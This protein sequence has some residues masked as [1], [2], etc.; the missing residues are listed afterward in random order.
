MK[1]QGD[2][3][4]YNEFDPDSLLKPGS[5]T[6]FYTPDS[7]NLYVKPYPISHKDMLEDDDDLFHD[8]YPNKKVNDKQR[9]TLSSRG[10]ALLYS[11]VLM[12]RIGVSGDNIIIAVWSDP[13]PELF[14]GFLVKLF[15][16]H[17]HFKN[18][19]DKVVIVTAKKQA[20]MLN[21]FM[22]TTPKKVVK[23]KVA[24]KI[25]KVLQ[26]PVQD[27]TAKYKI[28]GQNYSLA[29]L[30]RLRVSIH[31]QA[32]S[33]HNDAYSVLCHPDLEKYPELN[34]YRPA[35]CSSF[36]PIR[37]THPGNWRA[38][39]RTSGLPYIYSYGE[40]FTFKDWIEFQECFIPESN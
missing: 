23:K 19:Q 3:S 27:E 13:S 40:G 38:A 10:Q 26:A 37:K 24:S 30:Q 6:F 39:A 16:I 18:I 21:D 32:S 28:D 34:G 15:E 17:P 29:D 36:Q 4:V 8:V 2:I 33:L 20:K 12:G 14:N 31:S 11:N 22:G 7:K 9:E 25:P 1:N 35:S 5:M